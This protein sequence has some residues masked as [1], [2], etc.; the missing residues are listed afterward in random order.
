MTP[1]YSHISLIYIISQLYFKSPSNSFIFCADYA[2]L[3]FFYFSFTFRFAAWK[4]SV[5][6]WILNRIEHKK[7]ADRSIAL[8]TA[9][10]ADLT[11]TSHLSRTGHFICNHPLQQSTFSKPYFILSMILCY[12]KKKNLSVYFTSLLIKR[13]NCDAY[14]SF[15]KRPFLYHYFS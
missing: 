3:L 9:Q 10:P 13:R 14:D 15:F 7:A 11:E 5:P 8:A 4:S 2:R 6:G 12:N 1:P